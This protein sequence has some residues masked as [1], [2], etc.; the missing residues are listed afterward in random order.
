MTGQAN[1]IAG[2]MFSDRSR[3]CNFGE[4]ATSASFAGG[5]AEHDAEYDELEVPLDDGGTVLDGEQAARL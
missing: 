3:A 2:T 4:L 1:S 5:E